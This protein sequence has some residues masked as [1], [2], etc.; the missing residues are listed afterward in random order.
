MELY[1][2]VFLSNHCHRLVSGQGRLVGLFWGGFQGK[3]APDA[4]LR[5]ERHCKFWSMILAPSAWQK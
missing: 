5:L 2:F 4:V 1:A 3:L